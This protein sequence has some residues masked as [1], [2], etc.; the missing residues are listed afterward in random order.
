MENIK[1]AVRFRPYNKK[2]EGKDS[3]DFS[4]M[5]DK[6]QV[7][8]TSKN[9][10]KH[11]FGFDFVFSQN[12]TQEGLYNTLVKDAVSWVSQGFNSTIFAYGATASGK[13]TTLFGGSSEMR[14]IIPRCCEDLF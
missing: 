14:G 12:T 10:E 3:P 13:T 5:T 4:L 7:A 11:Q 9:V 1:V 6:K 8:I 2:E